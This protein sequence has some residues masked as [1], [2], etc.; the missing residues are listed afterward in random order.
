MRV[1]IGVHMGHYEIGQSEDGEI[2][3]LHDKVVKGFDYYGPVVNTAA[4]IEDAAF[5]GQTMISKD[6][7][8]VLSLE[9]KTACS[10]NEI[11]ELTLRGVK[12]QVF[13]YSVL[14]ESLRGRRFH[15]VFRRKSS[16]DS[17]SSYAN[18]KLS[19]KNVDIMTLTPVELQRGMKQMQ[20]M[21]KVLEEKVKDYE[22][23]ERSAQEDVK[24][25]KQSFSYIESDDDISYGG[26]D[27][28]DEVEVK[29]LVKYD[30]DLS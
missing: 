5:G 25:E 16:N 24:D 14:P 9:V 17:I 20:I 3:V 26:I 1:R 18:N 8:D 15:G 4:R 13:V 28:E 10:I 30:M 6:I 2:Q 27:D 21:I 19:F 7:F 29:P 22:E 12:D 23:K 11:G